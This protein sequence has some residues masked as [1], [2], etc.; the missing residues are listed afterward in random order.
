MDYSAAR[1]RPSVVLRPHS[2]SAPGLIL[3]KVLVPAFNKG[4]GSAVFVEIL[5]VGEVFDL[6][7]LNLGHELNPILEKF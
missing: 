7:A 2:I 5:R 3:H 6:L 4:L 1:V